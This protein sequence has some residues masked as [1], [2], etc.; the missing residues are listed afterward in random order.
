MSI[1]G[2]VW[3]ARCGAPSMSRHRHVHAPSSL[4]NLAS[5]GPLSTSVWICCVSGVS[6][7]IS[8]TLYTESHEETQ[9]AYTSNWPRYSH[10][11]SNLQFDLMDGTDRRCS[12]CSHRMT[13]KESTEKPSFR[14]MIP[15]SK[16]LEKL[17][18]LSIV[19]KEKTTISKLQRCA[20]STLT[21]STLR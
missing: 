15:V 1:S 11:C 16:V 17:L 9:N 13:I 7:I 20:A 19:S 12:Y 10:L 21:W 14:A 3:T 8:S 5:V 4:V 2:L 18:T 6:H